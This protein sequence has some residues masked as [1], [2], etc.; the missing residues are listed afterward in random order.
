VERHQVQL[1]LFLLTLS[2][3]SLLVQNKPSFIYRPSK[4][5]ISLTPLSKENKIKKKKKKGGTKAQGLKT[6]GN[7]KGTECIIYYR[8]VK[9]RFKY[10]YVVLHNTSSY[11]IKGSF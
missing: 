3:Q 4:G 11:Q 1:S 2:P 5:S 6:T 10:E 8:K 9:W 7:L